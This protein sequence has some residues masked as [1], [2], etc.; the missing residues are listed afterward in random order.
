MT[1]IQVLVLHCIK[2][3]KFYC[4]EKL[5]SN[6]NDG[7]C[8]VFKSK[9]ASATISSASYGTSYSSF[10]I[11][12]DQNL[13]TEAFSNDIFNSGMSNAKVA[14]KSETELYVDISEMTA[15]PS[16]FSI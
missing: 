15:P 6:P 12:A 9:C 8:Y 4:G 11:V 13:G 1:H 5:E 7:E 10:T 14:R 2:A 16:S 3:I